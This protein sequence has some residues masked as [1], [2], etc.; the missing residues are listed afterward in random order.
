MHALLVCGLL[1][2][3]CGPAQEAESETGAAFEA[4]L[5]SL[6]EFERAFARTAEAR[7][8]RDAFLAYL[9]DDAILFR[10]RAVNGKE[11]Y[12][13]QP[14]PGVLSWVPLLADVSEAGDLG[15][16]T[17][18]WEFRRNPADTLVVHGNYFSVWKKGP[19][20][21]W[22]VAIDIGTTNPAP[23]ESGTLRTPVHTT[24]AA[25]GRRVKAREADVA[26]EKEALLEAD[27]EFARASSGGGFEQSLSAFVTPD[28]RL[29]R[30]SQ[31]PMTGIDFVQAA[32]SE[33]PGTL[34]W[35]PIG[36]DVSRTGDLGYTYGEYVY[37]SPGSSG[38]GEQGNYVRAWRREPDG[39]W[40][41]VVEVISPVPASQGGSR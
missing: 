25:A 19:D 4:Q 15:Y 1:L 28:V 14:A 10:P 30:T 41:V 9:A 37:T 29:L 3:S 5:Q 32:H 33:R 8:I 38:T 7:G 2:S 22:K 13:E 16:T 11:W 18:P 12:R 20:G 23:G 17:G 39:T 26:S 21:T 34:T 35:N 36:G 6:V 40:K 31:Q 27:R 24:E